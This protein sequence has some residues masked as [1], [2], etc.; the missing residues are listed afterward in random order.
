VDTLD[1]CKNLNVVV[2]WRFGQSQIYSAIA[3]RF[4]TFNVRSRSKWSLC[5]RLCRVRGDIRSFQSGR[6]HQISSTQRRKVHGYGKFRSAMT[7]SNI[8][9]FNLCFR[10]FLPDFNV[11]SIYL[12]LP[13]PVWSLRSALRFFPLCQGSVS[14]TTVA[15]R[16]WR[17]LRYLPSDA[18]L[19]G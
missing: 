3:L 17:S 14:N 19:P 4:I 6:N 10:A 2:P 8:R 15:R 1:E 16:R 9:R 5:S 7:L 11:L 12:S 18:P 13:I